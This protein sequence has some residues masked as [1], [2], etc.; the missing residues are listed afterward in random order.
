MFT[1]VWLFKRPIVS[2]LLILIFLQPAYARV[3][4]LSLDNLKNK[5][6]QI[7]IA[8]V[9]EKDTRISNTHNLAWTDYTLIV[10]QVIKGNVKQQFIISF[11]SAEQADE[12]FGVMNLPALEVNSTYLL[13]LHP[14]DTSYA[15]PVVGWNQGAFKEHKIDN[16]QIFISL[17]GEPLVVD[18]SGALSRGA[19]GQVKDGSFTLLSTIRESLQDKTEEPIITNAQGE[20][21]IQLAPQNPIKSQAVSTQKFAHP[22]DIKIFFEY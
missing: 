11:A 21:I 16:Q 20:V 7:V 12:V 5:A 9:I 4:R 17:D 13:F 14:L 8:K 22:K 2:I 6:S 3:A 19:P 10:N 15:S 18:E 1:K